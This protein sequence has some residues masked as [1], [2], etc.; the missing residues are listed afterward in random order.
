MADF[1][2]I[3]ILKK[4][5]ILPKIMIMG[6]L[7]AMLSTVCECIR[8]HKLFEHGDINYMLGEGEFRE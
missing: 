8:G 1:K 4:D 5:L 2:Y 3:Q 7:G 6:E